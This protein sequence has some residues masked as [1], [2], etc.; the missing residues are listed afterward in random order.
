LVKK[1]SRRFALQGF[2]DEFPLAT[3]LTVLELE[4]RSGAV[5]LSQG[6]HRVRG[7]KLIVRAGQV[8]AAR[9]ATT[10]AVGR[11]AVHELLGWRAGRF[12]FTPG[13]FHLHDE[14]KTPTARLLLE[15]AQWADEVAARA[16]LAS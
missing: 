13:D 12:G 7:G 2:L 3:L 16:A 4:R 14:V 6:P 8:I 1:R 9:V 5:V 10:G 15:A 11:A